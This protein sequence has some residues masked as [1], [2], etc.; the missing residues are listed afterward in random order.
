MQESLATEHSGE[1][2]ADA[3]EE[4]LD[5][6]AV[7]N[8]GGRHLQTTRWNVANGGLHVVGDPFHKVAAVLVLDIE[9]LL[10]DFFHRYASTEHGSNGEVAAMTRI[11]SSHH[12]LGIKHL[13]SKLRNSDSSVLL[14]S[15]ASKGSKARH[16]EVETREG[17]H[18]DSKLTEI[19]IQ[20]TGESK[21]CGHATH[22]H[23]HQM[24]QITIGR[25]CKLKSTEADVIESLIVDAVSLVS[26]L[27]K[28]VNREGGV[29]WFYDRIR[30]FRR[31]HYTKTV[32]DSVRKLLTDLRDEQRTHPGA[33][34]ATKGVCELEALETVAVFGLLANHIENRVYQFGPFCV[35]TF[36][37]VVASSALA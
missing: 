28:L 11:A 23:G 26:V 7:T 35:V 21:R 12:V 9:H 8:E 5:G 20:L 14:G 19:C 22:C 17:D 33:G 36:C 27:Y 10:V 18:V 6:G 2:L 4:L 29:V 24:V 34:A 37:P 15:T 31:W 32:H 16:E 25:V 13:L 1:L 3:L 30:H